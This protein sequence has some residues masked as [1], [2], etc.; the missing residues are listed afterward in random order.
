MAG[1]SPKPKSRGKD[2]KKL[3]PPEHNHEVT[4]EEFE[5]EGMGVASKE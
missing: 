4:V 5:R 3:P 1:R 2:S